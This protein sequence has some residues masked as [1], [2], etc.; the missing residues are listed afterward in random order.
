MASKRES[1]EW[2]VEL[3]RMVGELPWWSIL[4]IEVRRAI[5]HALRGAGYG[6]DEAFVV[7]QALN[8][9]IEALCISDAGER[10]RWT[11][12]PVSSN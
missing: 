5:V 6:V 3:D 4:S 8:E 2:L 10:V 1:Q 11:L 9:E 12:A 7:C